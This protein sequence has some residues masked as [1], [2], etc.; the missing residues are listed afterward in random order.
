[1][2]QLTCFSPAKINLYL[3]ITGK[4]DDG[5][6]NLDSIFRAL[7]FGDVL[8]FYADDTPSYSTPCVYL[9]GAEGITDNNQDNLIV[10]AASALSR[11][12]QQY[13]IGRLS[14][15][16]IQLTKRIPMGAGLGG[17]SS[18]AATTLL[19]LNTLWQLDLSQA[20]LCAIAATLGADVPFFV[21]ASQHPSARATGIGDVLR[22]LALPARRY[23][24]LMPDAHISTATLF[25][26]PLLK[27]DSTPLADDSLNALAKCA[28][29]RL[30]DDIGNVF[31]P[32]VLSQSPDITTAFDYLSHLSTQ[33]NTTA[34]MTGTGSALFLPIDEQIASTTLDTWLA[35]APCAA[36]VTRSL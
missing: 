35:Q 1:M 9:A 2:A 29:D 8:H 3:H 26:H 11:H 6:H 17:G 28:F 4:R 24:L 21:F 7:D 5:Y 16:R 30:P 20:H 19:A 15:V 27:K 12:A 36:V 13:N 32:P 22:P 31:M 33:T 34:R 25:L 23:L 18:N 10:K 14:D